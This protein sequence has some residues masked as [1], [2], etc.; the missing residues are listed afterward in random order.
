MPSSHCRLENLVVDKHGRVIIADLGSAEPVGGPFGAKPLPAPRG[1]PGYAPPE[2]LRSPSRAE[3]V[4]SPLTDAWCLSVCL[5]TCLIFQPIQPGDLVEDPSGNVFPV[6]WELP[7]AVFDALR[8]PG[9]SDAERR[10]GA[11]LAVIL[12]ALH[13]V[14]VADRRSVIELMAT[15]EWGLLAAVC[16]CRQGVPCAA[17]A[18]LAP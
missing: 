9:A 1:T 7:A 16:C 3:F 4:L 10:V 17:C 15:R 11:A 13:A 18:T 12:R 6:G 5:A 14:N 8:A 2:M